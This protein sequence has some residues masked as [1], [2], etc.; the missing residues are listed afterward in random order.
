[1]YAIVQAGGK[2]YRVQPGDELDLDLMAADAGSTIEL[3]RVLMV[4]DG[5]NVQIGAPLVSGAKVV[6][7]V[8]GMHQGDKIKVFRYKPKVRYRRLT[9]HRQRYTRVKINEIV[10]A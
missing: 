9:G 2:Q 1:M 6:A 7:E 8:I 4:S 10:G 5:D 3:D